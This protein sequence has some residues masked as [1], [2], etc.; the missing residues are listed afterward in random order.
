MV[1]ETIIGQRYTIGPVHYGE[2]EFVGEY[3]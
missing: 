2:V 1:I 3:G